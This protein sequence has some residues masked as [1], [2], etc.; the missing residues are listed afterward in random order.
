V[1]TVRLERDVIIGTAGHIDHGKTALVHAL[2]GVDTDRLP[3]EKRRGITIDLGFAPLRLADGTVAGV[4]DVPGHEAFVRTMLAGATGIDLA[5]LVVAADEGPM[6]QTREHLAILGLLGVRGG[7]VALTKCDLVEDEWLALVEAE[8]R[9]VLA[10]TLLAQAPIV[11]TSVVAGTGLDA[12]RAHI[13]D[14]LATAPRRDEGDLFRLP[15]DRAF[16]VRGTG[17]VVTGTV[18]SGTLA[19][20]ATVRILPAG[21]SARVR[22]IQSHG[23]KVDAARPGTRA[24][25]ALAGVELAD[26][27]RGAVIVAHDSWQPTDLLR[28]EVAL[29]ADAPA[30]LRARTRVR[31]HLG[32][33]E[34]GARIV[35]AD[36]VLAP[37]GAGSARLV[38]DAPLVA[39]AGDRFVLRATSPVVTIG[40]G[41][42]LDPLAESR[43][44]RPLPAGLAAPRE[45][46]VHLVREAGA[47]GVARATLPMR[48]GLPPATIDSM[49]VSNGTPIVGIGDRLYDTAALEAVRERL[50]GTVRAHHAREPLEPGASLQAVRAGLRA[51]FGMVDE[52][53]RLAT[54]SGEIAIRGG[55]ISLAGWAPTPTPAQRATLE[56]LRTLLQEA[57]REPPTVAELSSRLGP[58]VS[59]LL[60][61]LERD[62]F[63]VQVEE[64]RYYHATPLADLF[65]LL[66]TGMEPGREYTPAELRDLLGGSRRFLIPLLEYCDRLGVT[67]RRPGGRTR[68][69][70]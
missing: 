10:G 59:P 58:D 30:P 63:V 45:R 26:V 40:G 62:G 41:T 46:L 60:R 44:V 68:G 67:D 57:G 52:V 34:V 7:V 49:L 21:V 55:V 35:A 38:L 64:E 37:G 53:I 54:G 4:V 3:E 70:T 11:A 1:G 65:G 69:G 36:G 13:G 23:A 27:A 42:V 43:R 22:G 48:I 50:I 24:A 17:T 61:I 25:I 56:T 12:L 31:L 39:R 6:P 47:A 29:L 32:T 9:D 15:V 5:L 33:Q 66:R 20:D 2:T 14:A 8:M 51:P 16:T 28:A 18:W 19:S